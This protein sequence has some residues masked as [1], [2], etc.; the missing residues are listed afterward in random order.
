MGLI[1]IVFGIFYLFL[2]H[3]KIQFVQMREGQEK[4]I[5]EVHEYRKEKSPMR[6]QQIMLN[7]PYVYFK[8]KDRLHKLKYAN[9]WTR[10]FPIGAEI[11][12]FWYAGVLYYWHAMDKGIHRIVPGRWDF[13]NYKSLG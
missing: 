5:A 9:N 3:A 7:Y 11:P 13:W 10:P 8:G 6:N 2:W 1:A 4:L 12:V